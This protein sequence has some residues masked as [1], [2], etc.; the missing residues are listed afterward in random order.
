LNNKEKNTTSKKN[1]LY[2]LFKHAIISEH[3]LGEMPPKTQKKNIY[4]Y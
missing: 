2:N 4:E 3:V 1:V